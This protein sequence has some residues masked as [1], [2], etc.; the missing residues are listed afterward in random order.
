M[1]QITGV[2]RSEDTTEW[3][4]N[5]SSYSHL[6]QLKSES[7]ARGP[8]QGEPEPQAK[9]PCAGVRN[10]GKEAFSQESCDENHEL[11]REAKPSP[12]GG[13]FKISKHIYIALEEKRGTDGNQKGTRAHLTCPGRRA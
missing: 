4:D 9:D 8:R 10:T 2:P 1:L 5:S 3:L 11:E 13:H 7:P 12:Q 6:F